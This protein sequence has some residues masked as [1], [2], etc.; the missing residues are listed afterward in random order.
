MG[1]QLVTLASH[2][3]YHDIINMNA[4]VTWPTFSE[5]LYLKFLVLMHLEY[6][7]FDTPIYF[8]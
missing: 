6:S 7:D 1:S 2:I 8:I 4:Y 5:D 3:L